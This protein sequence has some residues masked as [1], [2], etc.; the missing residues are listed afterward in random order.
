MH[1]AK[2]RNA[3]NTL[4]AKMKTMEKKERSRNI[5]KNTIGGFQDGG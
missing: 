5:T 4:K 1:H 2:E 3:I